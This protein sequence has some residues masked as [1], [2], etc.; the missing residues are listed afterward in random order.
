MYLHV[1][2]NPLEVQCIQEER[3]NCLDTLIHNSWLMK[4]VKSLGTGNE[5]GKMFHCIC[6]FKYVKKYK[7]DFKGCNMWLFF[8]YIT[9]IGH[10][11]PIISRRQFTSFRNHWKATGR[12]S[13][14][15]QRDSGDSQRFRL[16]PP[17]WVL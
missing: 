1:W 11:F 9:A 17:T 13:R 5:S 12:K 15:D 6:I 16:G 2:I 4:K 7:R 8:I 10:I 3:L 14:Q